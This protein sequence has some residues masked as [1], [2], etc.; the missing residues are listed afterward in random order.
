MKHVGLCLWGYMLIAEQLLSDIAAVVEAAGRKTVCTTDVVFVL[1]RLGRPIYVRETSLLSLEM[2]LL[3]GG[4]DSEK[5]QDEPVDGIIQMAF[6]P[7][8]HKACTYFDR[9]RN[10]TIPMNAHDEMD[11]WNLEL[12]TICGAMSATGTAE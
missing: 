7:K 2:K 1:N 5:L 12:G 3:T 9:S 8:M 4:R 10:R 11:F 6:R